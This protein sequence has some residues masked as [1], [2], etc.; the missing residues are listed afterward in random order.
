MPKEKIEI[1]TKK[2]PTFLWRGH[3]W[4]RW[5]GSIQ[6]VDI[7]TFVASGTCTCNTMDYI[8]TILIYKYKCWCLS[9]SF[10]FSNVTNDLKSCHV[11]SPKTRR[12]KKIPRWIQSS[13]FK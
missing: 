9:K 7:I 4:I 5:G 2:Q 8:H 11:L 10:K 6:E 1:Y 13:A 3:R 12:M